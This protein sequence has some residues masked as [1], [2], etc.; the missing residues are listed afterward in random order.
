MKP[1]RGEIACGR[2]GLFR[3]FG[4]WRMVSVPGPRAWP[5][6]LPWRPFGAED[7]ARS[8]PPRPP[9]PHG[10]GPAC[11]LALPNRDA[12]LD[13]VAGVDDDRLALAETFQHLRLQAVVVAQAQRPQ[14]RL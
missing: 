7:S 4:A 10:R 9:L 1:R 14:H 5:W 13:L 11:R 12:R 6:A 2:A 8:G 3:P